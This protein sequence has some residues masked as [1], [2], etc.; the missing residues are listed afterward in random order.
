MKRAVCHKILIMLSCSSFLTL[1][2]LPSC[3]KNTKTTTTKSLASDPDLAAIGSRAGGED[4]SQLQQLYAITTDVPPAAIRPDPDLYA[5][6]LLRQYRAD[7]AVVA[8]EIGKNE[9]F[10]ALLGGASDDFKTAPQDTYDATS[11]LAEQK[12]SEEICTAL[13]NPSESEQPGWHTILPSAPT[14]VDA[15]LL[16]LAQR[17]LGIPSSEI[18][19]TVLTSLKDI[20]TSD[21]NG[22]TVGYSNYVPACMMLSMDAEA[23]LL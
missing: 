6:R 4:D 23:L 21:A 5:R 18:S 3:G 12:V 16:F 8:K 15:N 20:V 13:V 2:G 7:G 9:D 19:S 17:F 1:A 14:E 11:L 22:G 10:R